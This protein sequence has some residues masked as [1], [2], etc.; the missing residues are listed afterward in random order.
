V[1]VVEIDAGDAPFGAGGAHGV[2]IEACAMADAKMKVRGCTCS[3][4]L[5]KRQTFPAK[6]RLGPGLAEVLKTESLGFFEQNHEKTCCS[7][8]F[9]KDSGP[10]DRQNRL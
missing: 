8:C 7:Q 1:K 2:V 3:Y 10:I 5:Y 6:L 9:D 4:K